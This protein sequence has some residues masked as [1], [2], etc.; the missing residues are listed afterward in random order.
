MGCLAAARF[1]GDMT[2]SG[3]M[4]GMTVAGAA[5]AGLIGGVFFTFSGFVLAALKRLPAAQGIS[6]MQSIN[7]TAVTPPLMLALFGTAILS[8]VAGIWALRSWAEPS[9][10][11][12]LAGA[13]A[14]LAAVVIT[15]VANV[16]LN[17]QLAGLDPQ[18]GDAPARW[19]S[20][21]THWTVWNNL[22]G[23]AAV[24]AGL[25]LVIALIRR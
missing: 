3:T 20:F 23:A 2:M 18:A 10:T 13:L 9:A 15:T 16:P 5:G 19:A 25:C 22:R 12:I 24:A 1:H 7:K 8:V 21:L 17:N 14:Y 6:A 11:W 4:Q